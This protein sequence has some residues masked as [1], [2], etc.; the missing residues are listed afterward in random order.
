MALDKRT[1]PRDPIA[2]CCVDQTVYFKVFDPIDGERSSS[3]RSLLSATKRLQELLKQWSMGQATET[4]IS[5]AYV[6]VGEDF[7]MTIRAFEY[8]KVDLRH[9]YSF[10]EELRRPLEQCL[11]N[12]PSTEALDMYMPEIRRALY[13][14]YEG[15]RARKDVWRAAERQMLLHP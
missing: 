11:V 9:I 5:D 4:Q 2:K 15:I 1:V 13:K 10:P 12:E 7:N 14:L 8:Y 6:K 3:V